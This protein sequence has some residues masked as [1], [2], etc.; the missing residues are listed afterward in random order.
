MDRPPAP[1][2]S[3]GGCGPQPLLDLLEWMLA[4]D[5]TTLPDAL[6]RASGPLAAVLGA[7]AVEAYLHDSARD[8]LVPVGDAAAPDRR[9]RA[10][11]AGAARARVGEVYRTGTARVVRRRG[12]AARS[13]LAV[14]LEIDGQRRGVVQATA[15]RPDAWS[16]DDVRVLTAVVHLLSRLLRQAARADDARRVSEGRLAAVVAGAPLLLFAFDHAGA[17]TLSAGRG[18]AGLGRPRPVDTLGCSVF[19]VYRAIPQMG[20]YARRALAGEACG[21]VV[22]VGGAT[23]DV[24]YTPVRGGSGGGGGDGG[25]IGAVGVVSEVIGVVTDITERARAEGALR[26]QALHDALTGLPN[27]LL[28]HDRLAQAL[29]AARR[30]E[31]PLALLLLDLDRFKEVNDTFG[32]HVGDGLLRQ[33]SPRLQRLLRA[34]DTV[35]RLGGDEFAVLLP[36]DG[37]EAALGVAAKLRAALDAPFVVEGHTLA[38]GVTIGVAFAPAH[39]DD[40]PTL[41]RHA[42][43]ALYTAKRGRLGVAAYDPARDTHSP[44]RLALVADLRR[45]I[46]AGQL[47]LHYQ[48]KVDLAGERLRGVEAL[49]RWPHPTQGLI[50]PDRFI[51]LAEQT[52]L[53]TRL[54][55]QVL[56]AALR[57]RRAWARVGLP[58]VMAVNL[59]MADLQDPDLPE[60]IGGLLRTYEVPRGALRI[61][62]TESMVMVDTGRALATLATLA[63]LGVRAAIDDFGTGYSSLASL[64]RLPV[65]E[66]KIDR[67][68]VREVAHD[69]T[70]AAIVA[71]A[72]GL[73]H[74]LGLRVVAEGVEDRAAW[75]RVA[76]LGCDTVQGYYVSPPL[77][78][79]AFQRWLRAGPYAA[80][81]GAGDG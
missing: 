50:P 6:A 55:R 57:Q 11:P 22:T 37:G 20:A 10:R 58:L 30:T 48:P 59:S 4:L 7:D 65:D 39:G 32:H 1:R 72:I 31:R 52:G 66:L 18:L 33:A 67:G 28:L 70:D 43:V 5:M 71:A 35:A 16:D 44:E 80:A 77:P 38:V 23:F 14:P 73:G 61:E 13:L 17:I 60:I 76:A 12:R 53:I 45:A 2:A 9:R 19:D 29:R 21:G 3:D 62:I 51:P 54:T 8:A 74:G 68:F 15:A 40:G 49:V 36:N 75:D 41:L 63:E 26:H 56:R 47:R 42:D 79:A 64:K 78:A 24:S 81:A 27:R 46:D 25:N 34:S 69:A